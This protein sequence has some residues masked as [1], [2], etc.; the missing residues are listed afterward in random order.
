M[1]KSEMLEMKI[2][3]ENRRIF[4]EIVFRAMAAFLAIL[5][6][7]GVFL[8]LKNNVY[9]YI[10]AKNCFKE[11]EEQLNVIVSYF[12]ELEAD[13]EHIYSAYM[14]KRGEIVIHEYIPESINE[15]GSYK[16]CSSDS[17]Y[18][19]LMALS[20]KYSD[21]SY[22]FYCVAARYS[23]KGNMKVE[24]PVYFESNGNKNANEP[25]GVTYYLVYHDDF[26]LDDSMSSFVEEHSINDNWFVYYR[27]S[28]IG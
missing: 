26:V 1:T 6:A 8:Y 3:K 19:A 7:I 28:Y 15:K 13:Y 24:I 22:V 20:D 16:D 11:N 14:N 18:E 21:K 27:D 2:K 25:F 17:G 23:R 5:V 9:P 4:S 12:A 10:Y